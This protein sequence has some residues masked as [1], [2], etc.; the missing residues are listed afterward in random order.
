[1]KKR[2]SRQKNPPI[3]GA[4]DLAFTLGFYIH[5]TSRLRKLLFDDAFKPTGV[6]RSQASVLSCLWA[7]DAITQSTLAKKLD[8]GKVALGSLIDRLESSGMIERHNDDGDRRAKIITLT[9]K[10]RS[11]L[12][13]LRNLASE[14]NDIVL[15]GLSEKELAITTKTLKK[16]K[17]N[18]MAALS[19]D[20]EERV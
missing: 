20:D 13:R 6:T 9:S 2:S 10:G 18:V 11:T 5:D 1:M 3:D 12:K 16:M 8:L 17:S 19:L 4:S 14:T 7:N 15:A